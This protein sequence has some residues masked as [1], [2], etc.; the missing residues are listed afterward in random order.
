M[1]FWS[2]VLTKILALKILSYSVIRCNTSA[3]HENYIH[4]TAKIAI[5]RKF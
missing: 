4:E 3:N 5:T 1:D 2:I